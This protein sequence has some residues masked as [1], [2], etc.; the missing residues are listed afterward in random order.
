M[1][2]SILLA[3]DHEIFRE[4]LQMLLSSQ[5]DIQVI[6]QARD[7]LE[8][9]LLTQRMRPDL[10]ILDML[11]PGLNGLDALIQIKQSLPDCQVI[12]LS[13]YEEERDVINALQHG[14]SGYV[15]KESSATD[16][17]QAIRHAVTGRHFLSP[18]LVERAIK[19]YINN[20]GILQ[21]N[22]YRVLTQRERE[23]LHL[24]A[25]GLSGPQIASQLSI[26]RRTV[27]THRANLMHKLGLHSQNDLINYA[28]EHKIIL[29]KEKK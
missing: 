23:V 25:K 27:E 18:S 16:L 7:G 8:A 22:D 3:D 9:V 17:L 4:G 15:L 12:M 2:I 26:S 28:V 1:T 6:G 21:P 13:L 11:M 5:S 19:V 14:A 20:P 10:V 24:S 29:L